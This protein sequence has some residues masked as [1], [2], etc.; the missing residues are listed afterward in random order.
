[1][2][3]KLSLV[4]VFIIF[5]FSYSYSQWK[6]QLLIEKE[7]E[8]LADVSAFDFS[9][10]DEGLATT[11]TSTDLLTYTLYTSDAG[12][13]WK[14]IDTLSD[15]KI[16][17][18]ALKFG[19]GIR[20]GFTP[21]HSRIDYYDE[22]PKISKTYILKQF[23]E[24]SQVNIV[25][26]NLVI[27]IA[28]DTTNNSIL[29]RMFINQDTLIIEK[30]ISYPATT[31]ETL[32]FFNKDY[33]YC[34]LRSSKIRGGIYIFENNLEDTTFLVHHQYYYDFYSQESG[35]VRYG[36]YILYTTDA[37]K[38][39]DSSAHN[40]GYSINKDFIAI[41]PQK[42]IY[43]TS[44]HGN[45][46]SYQLHYYDIYIG[47]YGTSSFDIFMDNKFQL[48]AFDSTT[49]YG[50]V[51][52]LNIFIKTYNAAGFTSI[53]EKSDLSFNCFPNPA[54]EYVEIDLE[55]LTLKR[56]VEDLLKIHIYNYMGE[57]AMTLTPTLSQGEME[58]RID[59]SQLPAGVYFVKIG[60]K[61][62]KFVKE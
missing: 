52:D 48:K 36:E 15:Y 28:T 56:G 6:T 12:D 31:F 44:W 60:D 39:W 40:L 47:K 49:I 46:S 18:I 59:I 53:T 21:D 2:F 43:N 19:F 54:G 23:K 17:K 51:T 26:S 10:L 62:G 27:F 13:T 57:C 45:S 25:D 4:T 30:Q 22:L 35:F 42:I 20:V 55:K 5:S 11:T 16:S 24:I 3:K 1:M 41:S 29:G 33:G 50:L 58:L 32:D 7:L 38:S 8:K 14:V 37:G 61:Y 34:S 9:S